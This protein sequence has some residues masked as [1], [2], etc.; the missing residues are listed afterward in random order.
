MP[1]MTQAHFSL[2]YD[3]PAVRDGEIDVTDLAPALLALGQA[4]KATGKIV[5]GPDADV[6]LK[7][8][9]TK[10][11]SF[12]VLMSAVTNG[13]VGLAWTIIKQFY[14]T[15]DVQTAKA[16]VETLLMGGTGAGAAT[17]GVVKFLKWRKGRPI[18]KQESLPNGAVKV[19][20]ENVEIIL[21]P[22]VLEAARDP[23]VRS[24]IEKAI[25]TPLEKDGIDV[26]KFAGETGEPVVVDKSERVHFLSAGVSE[27]EF[28]SVYDKVF[29]IVT[30]SFKTG[31]KWKLHDGQG[32]RNVTILDEEFLNRIDKGLARFAKGDLLVCQVRETAVRTDG[33]FKSQYEILKVIEHR[34]YRPPE[35]LKL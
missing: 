4:V 10:T 2:T 3:G 29:S 17:A 18:E 24:G 32:A 11:G 27:S 7:V 15:E 8:R 34:P 25:A 21:A 13:D 26:V 19:T 12:E 1:I 5:L 22:G 20:I 35:T 9:T 30:L 16:V 23:V 33:G 31:N 14:Q 28:T 6:S